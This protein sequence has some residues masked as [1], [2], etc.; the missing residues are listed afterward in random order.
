ML[1]SPLYDISD[2]CVWDYCKYP[3]HYHIDEKGN[4]ENSNQCHTEV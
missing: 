2:L 3:E 4:V 1:N